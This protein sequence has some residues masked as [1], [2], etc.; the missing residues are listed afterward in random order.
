MK[1]LGSIAVLG[2]LA[3]PALAGTRTTT[4][5]NDK[6]SGTRTIVHDRETGTHS[7]DAEITRKSD[8]AVATRSYDRQR[9]DTGFTASGTA[10]GF[11]GRTRSFDLERTRTHGGSTTSGHYTGRRGETYNLSG[12]RSRTG[13]GFVANRNITNSRGAT[14]YNRDVMVARANGQVTR[15]VNTTRDQGFR[16]PRAIRGAAHHARRG[17]GRRGN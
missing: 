1:M 7:R 14:V 12:S 11:N 16:P 6:F 3:A 15:S 10:T 5:D 8:G 17:G 13:N 9:T 2:L 4:W